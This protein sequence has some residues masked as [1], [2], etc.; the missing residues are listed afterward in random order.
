MLGAFN[1]LKSAETATGSVEP[2]IEAI[3]K[4]PKN[5]NSVYGIKNYMPN[6]K[7]KDD[8]TTPGNASNKIYLKFLLN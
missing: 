7:S 1:Y 3:K 4:Y 5:P 6:A 2:K 8:K